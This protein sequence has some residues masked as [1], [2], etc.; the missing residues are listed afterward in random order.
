M[1]QALNPL[2]GILHGSQRYGEPGRHRESGGEV[3]IFARS[4]K[5]RYVKSPMCEVTL[6]EVTLSLP[7]EELSNWFSPHQPS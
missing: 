3:D 7:P 5:Y 6:Q 2:L 1:H 4:S